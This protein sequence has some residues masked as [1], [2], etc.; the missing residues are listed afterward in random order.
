MDLERYF[1]NYIFTEDVKKSL[2]KGHRVLYLGL[3]GTAKAYVCQAIASSAKGRKLLV[4]VNNLLNAEKLSEDLANFYPEDRIKVYTTPETVVEDLAIQSPEALSDR[5]QVMEWL[6]QEDQDGIVICSLFALKRAV[7]P[8]KEWKEWTLSIEK[9][10]DLSV[11]D[12]QERLNSLGYV[13]TQATMK[14]GEMSVRGDIVDCY[15]L[16]LPYPVRCSLGFDEVEKITYFDPNTQKSIE[17]KDRV[18][19]IPAKEWLIRG[20]NLSQALKDLQT[21][22]RNYLANLSDV[23][24]RKRLT[25]AFEEEEQVWKEGKITEKTPFFYQAICPKQE[26]LLDYFSKEDR[27]VVDD[28]PRLLEINHE[29]DQSAALFFQDKL[30]Q[31]L[32]PGLE[33]YYQNFAEVIHHVSQPLFYFAQWQR[34][35]GNIHFDCVHSFQTR[36]ITTFHQQMESLKIEIEAWLNRKRTIVIYINQADKLRELEETLNALSIFSQVSLSGEIFEGKVNLL[37]GHLNAGIEFVEGRLVLMGEGDIYHSQPKRRRQSSSILSNAERLKSY[38]ELKPGDYVVH[39][40]HGIGQF[41]GIETLEV[42]GTHKD[43]LTIMY[44]DKASIHV[45]I[46]QMDLVQKYVSSEGKAPRLNK[47]GGSEWHKTKQKVSR[48]IEDIADDLIDLYAKRQMEEGYAF[49]PDTSEQAEF[50][51]AFPYVETGDQLRSIQEI[52]ADM[53]KIQPMD[54]LLVGDVGFGKT[55]VAMRAAFKALM[56]GKQ[57]AFLVPTTV[58]AQQ[59]YETLSERFREYPFT[60]EL[61]SR[62]RTTSEQKEVIAGLKQGSVNLVVG[63]HR[64]LSQDVSFLDLG[65]LVVDEEQRFGVKDKER[66]KKL[67]ENVDVLTLTATPIP[68]TLNMSMM[69]VRDLSVI[70]TPPANRYPVQTYVMEQNYGA[71]KDAIERELARNGQVFYLFNNVK[72][73]QE[74]AS[75]IHQ[76]VP[77]AR[78]A[79]AHGRMTAN[80]LEEVLM[81]FLSG[82]DDVLVTTTI[83]ET[84]IDMP[85]VNTLLVEKADR[86][87]LSTLY[88]L[89]GRV[90]RSNRV[91]YAYFMYEPNK[92]LNE[93]SEKR[94]MALRDFTELGSGFK[95]A[96]R[97]LSIRGAGNLLGKQQHGFVNSVGYDLF[98]Q[99]LEEAI[100]KKQG[101]LPKKRAVITELDLQVDAYIPSTYISDENQKVEI[102]KRVN[103]LTTIDAM[104][105]LDEE[106][107]DRF[108]EP[109][110]EVQWLL[111][112]GGIKGLASQNGIEKI[113]QRGHALTLI[114]AK[115]E[116]P[117]TLT[118]KIFQALSDIPMK[119]Q[120]KMDEQKLMLQLNTGE[121]KVDAWLDYLIQ[122]NDRLKAL[123][124]NNQKKE[125]NENS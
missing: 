122:F 73:I 114:F 85:N 110:I 16:H 22:K 98:Q 6:A 101:K 1:Q 111:N 95:I 8:L 47:M 92:M 43:Y 96:M 50:E 89:R 13:R 40:N 46:D 51:A 38:Q 84:G 108:G 18:T 34:G 42:L 62:F 70:E 81:D 48:Q 88:Q 24:V 87:G 106:L 36:P 94:L 93:T 90:G 54:R 15:P 59:H 29:I 66:L 39:I 10:Q 55:E 86:M 83:I 78:V 20:E 125:A 72:A 80:Q 4:I 30:E 7:L 52:K 2:S 53:E 21:Y 74:K 107:L 32:L 11:S 35:Y 31:G 25:A 109:P 64:L 67:R 61:L 91:A 116:D 102:Y 26:T 27:I 58:L 44:A 77:E 56:D 100:Q 103:R 119:V 14:P 117:Q 69:G 9:G 60:V 115:Q 99:M 104:W 123:H 121:L 120:M 37:L 124:Q 5:L 12:L 105:D 17:E 33:T 71:V 41:I 65:L 118:S 19:I 63:T 82:D 57:V 97:D 79:I 68:R 113:Q 3:Q 112:V 23:E 28:L 76:L 49:S 45:P 75:E